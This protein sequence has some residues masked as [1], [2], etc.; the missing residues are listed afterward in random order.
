MIP[1]RRAPVVPQIGPR[2]YN[3]KDQYSGLRLH[4]IPR[5]T[6]PLTGNFRGN[7]LAP[8]ANFLPDLDGFGLGTFRRLLI[9]IS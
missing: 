9:T 5:T 3:L 4:A 8:T 6:S 7:N 2:G 1:A